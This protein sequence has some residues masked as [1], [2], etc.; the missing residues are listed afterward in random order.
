M[1]TAS[2]K[3]GDVPVRKLLQYHGVYAISIRVISISYLI[4]HPTNITYWM[5]SCSQISSTISI[6]SR[7]HSHRN[8]EVSENGGTP[9]FSSVYRWDFP[10]N[11]PSISGYPMTSWKPPLI[12]IGHDFPTIFHNYHL[13]TIWWFQPSEKYQNQLG[14]LATQYMEKCQN[15]PNHQPVKSGFQ[16]MEFITINHH[17]SPLTDPTSESAKGEAWRGSRKRFGEGALRKMT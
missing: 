16:N 1:I 5:I 9:Q 2:S 13:V 11:K 17:E 14:G 8:M 15:I 4:H 12:D 7:T 3:H 10:W 6:P